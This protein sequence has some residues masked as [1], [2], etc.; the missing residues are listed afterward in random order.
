MAVASFG[1][2][3]QLTFQYL[4]EEQGLTGGLINAIEKDNLGFLWV[5]TREGLYKYDGNRFQQ[6]KGF[7]DTTKQLILQDVRGLKKDEQGRLWLGNSQGWLTMIDPMKYELKSYQLPNEDLKTS[8]IWNISLNKKGQVWFTFER[9]LGFFDP[10]MEQFKLW[11]SHQFTNTPKSNNY[12]AAY[13]VMV[14]NLQD[15]IIWIGTKWGHFYFDSQKEKFQQ[16]RW[17]EDPKDHVKVYRFALNYHQNDSLLY[18]FGHDMNIMA[19]H[20]KKTYLEIY[21]CEK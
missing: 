18:L 3:D 6:F 13:A 21:L 10:L 20:K 16:L 2:F 5:S 14:D 7:A 17:P 11:E 9:G 19:F 8:T 4:G 12:N 1:Q 15:H